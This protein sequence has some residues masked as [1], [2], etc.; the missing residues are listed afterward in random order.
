MRAAVLVACAGLT[1]AQSLT[2]TATG[3][4]GQPVTF[5]VTSSAYLAPASDDGV[6]TAYTLSTGASDTTFTFL[7]SAAAF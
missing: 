4:D 6:E 2:E 3:A 5:P 1:L 7:V